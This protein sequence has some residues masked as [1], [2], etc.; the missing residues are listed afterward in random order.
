MTGEGITHTALGSRPRVAVVGGSL[1]GLTAALLLRDL[2]ADV[3]VFE[4]SASALEGRGVGIVSHPVTT[5]YLEVNDVIDV[6]HVSTSAPLR[7]YLAPDGTTAHEERHDYRLTAYST[8]WRALYGA[9]DAD[10]YHFDRELT[11]FAQDDTGVT[12]EFT[13]GDPYRADLMVGAD[14]VSSLSRQ[15][16]LP[17]VEPRYAGYVAWRGVVDERDLA[18]ATYSRLV[19]AVTYVLLP[20]SHILVYPI[21]NYDGAFEPG[22]RLQNFVWYR[23]VEA[24]RPLTELMT[25]RD[26][27]RRELS[28]PP[29]GVADTYVRELRA[30]ASQLLPPPVCEVVT[31]SAEP[32]LQVI[33]DIDVPR[34]ALGRCCLIGDAAFAV[35]P[36]TAAATAK[37]AADA[38]ALASAL[39]AAD[40]D[41]GQALAAWEP[42]QLELGRQL[43]ERARWLGDTSQFEGAWTPGDPDLRFGLYGPGE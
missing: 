15:L 26:G 41:V 1:S 40:G 43:L 33:F 39:E 21:P 8:L 12:L 20:D 31:K 42:G 35:R 14:G 36:H 38:W 25:D 29:G 11:S 13:S 19:D 24:G 28:M 16:L 9:F 23:N 4:R 22:A 27:N 10:R 34:M 7:R 17:E 6:A 5:R 2:G 3:H 37:G 32:F 18:P 30:A